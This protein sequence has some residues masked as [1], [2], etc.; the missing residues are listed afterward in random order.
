MND[1]RKYGFTLITGLITAI[2]FLG[3]EAG[4]GFIHVGVI[5]VT[6]ILVRVL[7][8]LDEYYQELNTGIYAQGRLIEI[9][10]RRGLM[11]SMSNLKTSKKLIGNHECISKIYMGFILASLVLALFAMFTEG[12][13]LKNANDIAKEESPKLHLVQFSINSNNALIQDQNGI[14]VTELVASSFLGYM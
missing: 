13:T 3:F 11:S 14:K 10:L 8:W 1:L 2:S 12:S 6:M 7:F 4:T 5:I 9:T